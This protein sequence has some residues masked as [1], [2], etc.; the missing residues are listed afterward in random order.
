MS[1][2]TKEER[3]NIAGRTVLTVSSI[4]VILIAAFFIFRL[5]SANPLE[6]EWVSEDNGLVL[7]VD[8]DDSVRIT[9]TDTE[10]HKVSVN[11]EGTVDKTEKIFTIQVK[12]EEIQDTVEQSGGEVTADSVQD[13]TDFIVGT[14]DYSVEQNTLTLTER[15]YGEQIVFERR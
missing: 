7:S 6:G 14:Y 1:Q 13:V 4:L 12:E 15:E 11:V 10:D 9:G 3:S 2:R 5:F 8:A